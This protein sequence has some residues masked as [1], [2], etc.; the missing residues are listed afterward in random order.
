MTLVIHNAP[1]AA[2]V[3]LAHLPF[4]GSDFTMPITPARLVALRDLKAAYERSKDG[5][6][7]LVISGT[8]TNL[9]AAPLR[10]VQLTAALRSSQHLALASRAVYCGNNVSTSMVTQMTPHEIEFFQKLQPLATFTLESSASCPFVA[11]FIDPP[12]GIAAY[13]V[14]VSQAVPAPAETATEPAT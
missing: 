13:D 1:A 11:V 4:V 10:V 14:S 2:E 12:E 3:V 7:A 5:H 9:G 6:V 8:A